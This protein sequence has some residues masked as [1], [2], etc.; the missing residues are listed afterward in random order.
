M[1][2]GEALFAFT[3]NEPGGSFQCRLDA[4]PWAGCVAPAK[5]R[6]RSLG[7]HTFAVRAIDKAGNIDPTPASLAFAVKPTPRIKVT[8][9]AKARA[10]KLF[11][12]VDPD[13]P[14]NQYWSLA[15]QARHDGRWSALRTLRTAGER[16]TRT[17]NLKKGTYR[18]KVRGGHG[19]PG[20]ASKG[21]RLKK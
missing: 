21:V 17:L 6:V 14:G 8:A 5:F 4:V 10:K 7:T 3:S 15:L 9:R 20:A 16:E 18:V 1:R 12:D 13:L 19:Y 11:V 2:P